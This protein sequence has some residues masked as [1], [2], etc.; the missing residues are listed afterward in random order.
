MLLSLTDYLRMGIQMIPV[1]G[2]NETFNLR[3]SF[4]S[5]YPCPF[6]NLALKTWLVAIS[7]RL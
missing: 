4:F 2:V 1:N 6:S 3:K 7:H 5:W